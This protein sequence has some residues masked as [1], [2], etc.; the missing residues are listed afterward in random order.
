MPTPE[1]TAPPLT[2]LRAGG[3]AG[4]EIDVPRLR[5]VLTVLVLAALAVLSIVF[6]IGG[7][8]K[9]S[10]IDSIRSHGV[11]VEATI[12]GCEGLL[13]GSGSNDAGYAC[14]GRFTL[15]GKHYTKGMP[16]VSF[17]KPGTVVREVSLPSDPGL[18]ESPAQ[19][20]SERASDKVYV[21]PS[22]LAVLFVAFGA[23]VLLRR[24]QRPSEG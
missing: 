9:N 20:A 22:V 21:L 8:N 15:N 3:G 19:A 6:F 10:Q 14:N 23:V 12:T 7:A 17:E 11:V 4:T 2:T 1:P 5:R 18:L 24:R 16:G 13:G